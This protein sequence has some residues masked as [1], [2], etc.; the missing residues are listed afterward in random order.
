ML[1]TNAIICAI[2]YGKKRSKDRSKQEKGR[3]AIQGGQARVLDK[4]T[5][6][7]AVALC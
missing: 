1:F 4:I 5:E 6:N 3:T 7:G 2:F